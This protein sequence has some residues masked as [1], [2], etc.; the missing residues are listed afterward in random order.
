MTT[1]RTVAFE[2]YAAQQRAAAEWMRES[3]EKMRREGY[4]ETYPGHFVKTE[5]DG[6]TVWVD[7]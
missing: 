2:Q 6:S 3:V 4:Q 7:L 5:P 1:L